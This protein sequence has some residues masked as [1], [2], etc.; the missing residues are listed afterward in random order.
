[1]IDDEEAIYEEVERRI[2]ERRELLR[3]CAQRVVDNAT[4]GRVVDLNTL[5]WAMDFVECTKPLGRPLGTGEAA[6]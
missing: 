2:A 1:M 4:A 3:L 5:R 6:I